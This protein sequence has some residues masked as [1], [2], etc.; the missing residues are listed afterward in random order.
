M[1]IKGFLDNLFKNVA[2]AEIIHDATAPKS[3]ASLEDE[4]AEKHRQHDD[5]P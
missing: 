2:T 1:R 3:G 4:A 5:E